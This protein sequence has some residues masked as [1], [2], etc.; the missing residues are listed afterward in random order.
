MK[1]KTMVTGMAA[2]LVSISLVAA[3]N[4]QEA[5]GDSG[6]S[7]RG[8][9]A[10]LFGTDDA[11]GDRGDRGRGHGRHHRGRNVERA[12]ERTDVNEDGV[13]DEI[14]FVDSR[15]RN[16]DGRFNRLD[17]D[18]DGLLSRAESERERRPGRPDIDREAVIACVRETIAD[19]DPENRL[20]AV[21]DTIDTNDDGYVDQLE[22][23]AWL[24]ARAHALFDRIDTDDDGFISLEEAEAA[25][26]AAIN[27]RRVIRA[28]ID[29]QLDLFTEDSDV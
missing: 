20:E 13:V 25:H 26:E 4:A 19:Y 16:I 12:F 10:G 7:R 17:A 22:L 3:V 18:D 27:L 5:G 29:E 1:M 15:T 2:A 14:E 24:E 11:R 21:F 23:S 8:G 9:E 6:F 28:C